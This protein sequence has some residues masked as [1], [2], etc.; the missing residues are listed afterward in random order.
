M[1]FQ[2]S[3]R[4]MPQ[5][6]HRAALDAGLPG[7]IPIIP[8]NAPLHEHSRVDPKNRGKVPGEFYGRGIAF[9]MLADLSGACVRL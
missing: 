1:T 8:P 6:L 9:G 3:L 4:L 2:E 5:M 7:T